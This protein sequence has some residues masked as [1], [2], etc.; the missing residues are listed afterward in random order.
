[1]SFSFVH[2]RRA[3]LGTSCAIVFGFGASQALASPAQGTILGCT[4][5]EAQACNDFCA[6]YGENVKGN[7]TNFGVLDCSCSLTP[8]EEP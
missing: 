7:C 8:P 1:M 2:L 3:L 6:T 5:W 4:R